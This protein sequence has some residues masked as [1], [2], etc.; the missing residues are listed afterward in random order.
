MD[1]RTNHWIQV[2]HLAAFDSENNGFQRLITVSLWLTHERKKL[3]SMSFQ[4]TCDGLR[5]GAMCFKEIRPIYLVSVRFFFC[6]FFALFFFFLSFFFPI[7]RPKILVFF[8]SWTRER[9]CPLSLKTTASTNPLTTGCCFSKGGGFEKKKKK[10]SFARK[11]TRHNQIRISEHGT[12]DEGGGLISFLP[13]SRYGMQQGNLF[14]EEVLHSKAEKHKTPSLCFLFFS[15]PSKGEFPGNEETVL[16]E[17]NQYA[18]GS[19]AYRTDATGVVK[20]VNFFCISYLC[21]YIYIYIYIYVWV[22]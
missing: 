21:I 15:L 2:T 8:F 20:S 12:F 22:R 19:F 11:L 5:K 3:A 7:Q 10:M 16:M 9:S 4:G 14:L 17:P 6:L 13:V 1:F 18:A